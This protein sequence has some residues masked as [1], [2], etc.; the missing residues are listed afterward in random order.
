[1]GPAAPQTLLQ[2]VNILD[3]HDTTAS[4]ALPTVRWKGSEDSKQTKHTTRKLTPCWFQKCQFFE[5]LPTP[6]FGNVCFIKFGPF[7]ALLALPVMIREEYGQMA[8]QTLPNILLSDASLVTKLCIARFVDDDAFNPSAL[9]NCS[10]GPLPRWRTESRPCRHPM[11]TPAVHSP[12]YLAAF[13]RFP[14]KRFI[15]VGKF[16][17]NVKDHLSMFLKLRFHV[18]RCSRNRHIC[19]CICKYFVV[20]WPS[21]GGSMSETVLHTGYW[22]ARVGVWQ[23]RTALL[24][25]P[26]A[27]AHTDWPRAEALRCRPQLV[28]SLAAFPT[29]EALWEAKNS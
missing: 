12:A 4:Q 10:T 9:S 20:F 29:A 19:A 8:H 11:P 26:S 5:N 16:E 6:F 2:V 14:N 25:L 13:A 28:L 7:S 27:A 21:P 24:P 17:R 22:C 3:L 23:V 18:L 1:M 15:A